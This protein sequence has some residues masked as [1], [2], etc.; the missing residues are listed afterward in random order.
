[1]S[2]FA[3]IEHRDKVEVATERSTKRPST[4]NYIQIYEY[5]ILSS[6]GSQKNTLYRVSQK[7]DESISILFIGGF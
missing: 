4:L 6:G 3:K 1:V 2:L 7:K 5:T